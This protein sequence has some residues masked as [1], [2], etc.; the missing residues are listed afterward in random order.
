MAFAL[1][2]RYLFASPEHLAWLFAAFCCVLTSLTNS[3]AMMLILS[4]QAN[5]VGEPN[6]AGSHPGTR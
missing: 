5:E 4:G 3:V 2:T 1:I 6:A